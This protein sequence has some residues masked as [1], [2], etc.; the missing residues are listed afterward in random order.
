MFSI[1]NYIGEERNGTS[2]RLH[3]CH[4]R[5]TGQVTLLDQTGLTWAQSFLVYESNEDAR[6][7]IPCTEHSVTLSGY[8][9][10]RDGHMITVPHSQ[11][12]VLQ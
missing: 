8:P 9:R 4:P 1:Y 10:R 11:N 3:L 6:T 5:R 7:R 12:R 2:P